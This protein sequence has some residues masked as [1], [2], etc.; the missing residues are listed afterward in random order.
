LRL[1]ALLLGKKAI[2][3]RLCGSLQ[4]DIGKTCSMLNWLPPVSVDK[5]LQ[6]TAFQYSA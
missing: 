4:V 5:A 6:R 1:G 3:D 2:A